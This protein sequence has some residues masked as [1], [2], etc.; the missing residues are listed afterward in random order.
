MT[1]AL[2]II[3]RALG[4]INV[5]SEG[6]SATAAQAESAL[7]ALND[8][9]E[10]WATENLMVYVPEQNSFALTPGQGVFSIGAGGDFNVTRPEEITSAFV[11]L[12]NI[13]YPLVLWTADQF[14]SIGLKTLQGGIP[15]IMYYEPS[16]PL[17]KIHLWSV[18]ASNMTLF[19]ESLKP[20]TRLTSLTSP[21]ALPPGY[22]RALRYALAVEQMADYGA[23]NSLII[24]LARTSKADIKR[25]NFRPPILSLDPVIPRGNRYFNIYQRF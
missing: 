4:S 5:L 18:P 23:S 22:E 17:A 25:R 3:E 14:A 6:E 21:I 16:Y 1:I 20:F 15:S 24:E 10:G 13:D 2:D 9:L 8:V 11:R 19:I 12:T 7:V